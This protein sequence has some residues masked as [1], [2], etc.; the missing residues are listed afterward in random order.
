MKRIFFGLGFSN[1]GKSTITKALLN[2]CGVYIGIFDGNNLAYRTTSSDSASQNRWMMLLKDKRLIFSNEIKPLRYGENPHQKAKLFILNNQT[3]PTS[4]AEAPVLQGKE[5]SYNNYLD[6]DQ[7]FKC[8]S[9]LG[10]EFPELYHCVI[11]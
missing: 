11:V 2:R 6:S 4:L 9:E 1:T 10:L 8:V 7:A 5:I 3:G